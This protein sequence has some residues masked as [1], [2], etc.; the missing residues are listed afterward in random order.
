M[1]IPIKIKNLLFWVGIT[2]VC[3]IA[4]VFLAPIGYQL[5]THV[6]H[7]LKSSHYKVKADIELIT[8]Q[9]EDYYKN[10]DSLPSNLVELVVSPEQDK[11]KS[12]SL[13]KGMACF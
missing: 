10:N 8:A 11:P 3:V 2:T 9:L 5:F 13:K 7:K 12:W 6:D 1:K 4:V